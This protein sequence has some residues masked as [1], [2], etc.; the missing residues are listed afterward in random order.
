MIRITNLPQ[1]EAALE[2]AVQREL[3][4]SFL[5]VAK[6]VVYDMA[7]A[8]I[9]G[10]EGYAGTPQWSGNA[11]A[12]WYLTAGQPATQFREY[13]DT[14]EYPL[15]EGVEPPYSGH[16]PR[17]EAL[18]IS[19]SR[20]RQELAAINQTDVTLYLTNTAPY[21]GQYQPYDEA[22]GPKFR[23]ANLWPMSPARN[24]VR[25]INS[26]RTA[27]YMQIQAWKKGVSL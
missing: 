3:R 21:L 17:Q 4:Q 12:N 13:F 20:I 11:A 26:L 25:T 16:E 5:P 6:A 15:P 1:F 27:S 22:G 14:P 23:V 18:Q 7:K 9:N 19:L 8:F 24:V 2:A 10:D